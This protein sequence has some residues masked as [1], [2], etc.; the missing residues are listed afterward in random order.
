MEACTRLPKQKA[1]THR[2]PQA[3]RMGSMPLH[4]LSHMRWATCQSREVASYP[5]ADEAGYGSAHAP[6]TH[7]THP[8]PACHTAERMGSTAYAAAQSHACEI[9][10]LPKQAS[11]ILP[12]DRQGG[13]WKRARA[14]EIRQLPTACHR[15]SGWD[16]CRCAQS[17]TREI[18]HLRK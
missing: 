14:C 2:L 7:G 4:N 15:R 11:T 16:L 6:A 18:G 12:V 1:T 3:E 5:S 17:H 13:I 9:V 10:H 8:L